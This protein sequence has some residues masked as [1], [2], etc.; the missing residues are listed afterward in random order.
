MNGLWY[1]PDGRAIAAQDAERLLSDW[2]GRVIAED[3]IP[4]GPLVVLVVTSFTV[5]AAAQRPPGHQEARFQDP[6]LLQEQP[7]ILWETMV[8]VEHSGALI[9]R[10]RS[11]GEAETGHAQIVAHVYRLLETMHP[12][13]ALA[14]LQQARMW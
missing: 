3:V 7:P 8:T 12:G 4:A 5:I 2:P 11:R 14:A 10:Y 9:G 1:G 13:Q 6:R